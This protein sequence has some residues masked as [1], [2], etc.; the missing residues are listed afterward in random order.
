MKRTFAI[1]TLLFSVFCYA[2]SDD[3]QGREQ[4]Q[5]LL[6]SVLPAAKQILI[7]Q[8]SI[9][10]YGGAITAE[11]EIISI[12]PHKD[13]AVLP[14]NEILPMLAQVFVESAASEEFVA[15]ALVYQARIVTPENNRETD[16]IA[17][18]LDHML[19]YS[20][21]AFL[22]FSVVDGKPVFGS[23]IAEPGANRVF[24]Q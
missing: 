13:D 22:P 9:Y 17:V 3:N 5:Q 18:A 20:I 11:G 12:A 10:P 14:L 8:G 7:E 2:Q 24:R 19:G 21:T 23:M 4:A 1:F 16:S 6:N 15:T